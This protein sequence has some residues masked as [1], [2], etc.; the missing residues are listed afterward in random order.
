MR[1]FPWLQDQGQQQKSKN[2]L[3]LTLWLV[4]NTKDQIVGLIKKLH[5]W[6]VVVAQLV[7]RLLKIPEVRGSNPVIGKNQYSTFAVLKSRK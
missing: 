6:A 3:I 4:K 2:L 7:E 5:Y 1:Q